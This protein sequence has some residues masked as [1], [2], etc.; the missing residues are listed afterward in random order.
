MTTCN[1]NLYTTQE[2]A[3]TMPHEGKFPLVA[4]PYSE[5]ALE[6]FISKETILFHHAR[7]L[8]AYVDNLNAALPGTSLHALSLEEVVQK[9]EGSI[10]NNAGQVLN[11]NLYFTQ[12]RPPTEHNIPKGRIADAIKAR[13]GCFDNFKK[14]FV[15]KGV[16]LFGSGWVWLSA[17]KQGNLYIT[18]EHNAGNPVRQ[19]LR[20]LLCFDVWEHAYYID[21]RNRRAEHLQGLWKLI[22]WEVVCKRYCQGRENNCSLGRHGNDAYSGKG[23]NCDKSGKSCNLNGDNTHQEKASACNR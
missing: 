2:L 4:L 22:D 1:A 15:E 19:G 8:K 23:G 21:Y 11:H 9:A 5:D 14:E 18:Q 10:L 12:L 13:F 7:H 17:D 16:T 20:P 3:Q 6:P